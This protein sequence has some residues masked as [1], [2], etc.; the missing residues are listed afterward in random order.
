[1]RSIGLPLARLLFKSG[2]DRLEGTYRLSIELPEDTKRKA[3]ETARQAFGLKP[4]Q[5]PPE[6]YTQEDGLPSPDFGDE[7]YT[8]EY[9]AEATSSL[10]REAFL[11][12]LFHFWERQSNLWL[13]VRGATY[14][15]QSTI[16]WLQTHGYT[17]DEPTIRRLELAA[18]CA[19]HG[20]GRACDTL[21]A[22]DPT[23]FAPPAIQSMGS[24]RNF[25]Q[26]TIPMMDSLF[27]AVRQS[28]PV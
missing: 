7:L 9:E 1:M 10:V 17:L 5:T 6:V 14:N 3:D 21:Y 26:T 27:S 2:L 23:F 11:I 22:L 13:G 16:G 28:G 18:N 25:V 24:S 20:P 19:K 15:H 12:S 8:I 4:G